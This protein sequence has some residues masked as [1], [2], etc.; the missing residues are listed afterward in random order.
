MGTRGVDN[1]IFFDIISETLTK[2]HATIIKHLSKPTQDEE[3]AKELNLKATIVRTLLND[4]H[5]RNLVEYER[6]KNKKTGWYTYL[7][8]AREDRLEGYIRDY[9]ENKLNKLTIDLNSEKDLIT[10]NCSCSRVS[11]E[12][13]YENTFVCPKCNEKLGEFNNKKIVNQLRTEIAK[14]NSLLGA[15]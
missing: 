6:T 5:A 2:E 3:I 13:A 7:W 15:K 14:I 11:F 12:I 10:F 9:L 1:S 4:L 8:M